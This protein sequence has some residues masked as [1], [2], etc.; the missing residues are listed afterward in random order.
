MPCVPSP[1]LGVETVERGRGPKETVAFDHWTAVESAFSKSLVGSSPFMVAAPEMALIPQSWGHFFI[2]FGVW[3][4]GWTSLVLR[5]LVLP[6][7][8][9]G[10][11]S[12]V[13]AAGSSSP[14]RGSTMRV[15]PGLEGFVGCFG[16]FTCWFPGGT[17]VVKRQLHQEQHT[18]SRRNTDK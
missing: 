16:F 15:C 1:P 11:G 6:A 13:D 18:P 5:H 3:L 4:Q 7:G 2:E 9:G 10:G 14:G 12:C 8:G 17:W